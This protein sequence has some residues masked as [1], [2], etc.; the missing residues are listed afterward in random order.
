[1]ATTERMNGVEARCGGVGALALALVAACSGGGTTSEGS[2]SAGSEVTGDSTGDSTSDTTVDSTSDTTTTGAT[3]G[4]DSGTATAATESDS[5]TTGPL[6]DPVT[7]Q[8]YDEVVF[9]DGYAGLV[10]EPV[11]EGVQRLRN[12]LVTRKIADA[13]LDA[14]QRTLHLDVSIGALCDNYDRIASVNLALT[15]KGADTYDPAAVTRLEI[16]RFITP[17]MNMNKD[18]DHVP[19]AF[20]IDHMIPILTSEALRGA[21]DLWL[22]LEVFGVPYAAQNEV[23]GCTGRIDVFTGSLSLTTDSSHP[24]Q[25]HDVMIPIAAKEAY[26]NYADGASDMIGTTTKTRPFTLDADADD[27]RLVLIT[28]NHGANAGGEEYIRRGH[29]VYIDMKLVHKYTPGRDSCEPFR[30]YNTQGNGIYGAS[31]KSDA[32]WQSFSNWCPGD[33][34]DVRIIEL[35]PMSA[36]EHSFVIDVPLA[37][38]KGGQGDFPFSLFIQAKTAG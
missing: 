5:E 32:E 18:P 26:N 13:E 6:P 1:M 2:A 7:M 21:N 24:A 25:D 22:E 30:M 38:F 37:E 20:N 23:P 34:I 11:P 29:F 28:S 8:F 16:G 36:G 4:T 27:V 9:Y 12:S 31:P 17:F 35:G 15:P 14:L 3:E 10:D 33:V 19:Y